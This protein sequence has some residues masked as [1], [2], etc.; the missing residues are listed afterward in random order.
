M[1]DI[2]KSEPISHLDCKAPQGMQYV[3]MDPVLQ[4]RVV[5]KLDLNLMPLVMAL[6]MFT[7]RFCDVPN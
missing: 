3:N 4:K 7:L 1:A 2:E 6:C 5:R